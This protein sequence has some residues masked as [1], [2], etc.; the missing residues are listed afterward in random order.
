[1]FI[2]LVLRGV[3]LRGAGRVLELVAPLLGWE[4]P[5][6]HW[7]T[8][9]LWL[10]RWGLQQLWEP[11]QVADDWVWLTDHSVQ[12]GPT[13]CLAVVGLRLRNLPAPGQCLRH[14]DLKLIALEPMESSNQQQVHRQLESAAV[15]TGP[16]RVIVDDHGADLHGGVKLFQQQHAGTVEIYDTK[17]KAACLLKGRLEKDEWFQRFN[18]AVGQIRCC[19]QQTELAYLVPPGAKLKSRFM[20]L[21][22][23]LQWA[24]KALGVLR[25]PPAGLG[26]TQQCRLQEKLGVLEEFDLPMRRWRQWQQVVDAAVDRVG[27]WGLYPRAA[28]DLRREVV[29]KVGPC[30]W[31]QGT[32]ELADDLV[33][34]VSEQS[35]KAAG[36]R[37]PG[38]TEVLESLFGRYKQLEKQQSKG[39]FTSLLAGFGALVSKAASQTVGEVIEPVRRAL[40]DSRT[41]ELSAW[42]GEK[43]GT[44]FC[45]LRRRAFA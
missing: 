21:G 39:G 41:R 26:E 20:N 11:P 28:E 10:L 45:S 40:E 19:L 24:G 7:T 27:R 33:K 6:P 16:P 44:T 18:G 34:F 8:G 15:R 32:A 14:S 12:I 35:G 38:S 42:C 29:E 43:L 13:K 3:S 17:H 31:E 9:R 30:P 4:G 1:M 5:L 22:P 36:L 2:S 25:N 37:V 23:M